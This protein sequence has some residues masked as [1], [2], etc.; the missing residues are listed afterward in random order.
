MKCSNSLWWWWDFR[1]KPHQSQAQDRKK[2]YCEHDKNTKPN[3]EIRETNEEAKPENR[4]EHVWRGGM[5]GGVSYYLLIYWDPELNPAEA[6][7]SV[8]GWISSVSLH[9]WKST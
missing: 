5:G 1:K 3:W 7:C 4:S 6:I 2:H 8:F 9:V